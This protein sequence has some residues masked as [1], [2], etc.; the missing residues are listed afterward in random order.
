MPLNSFVITWKRHRM[1][2]VKMSNVP[3]RIYDE[4]E[5][6]YTYILY[7]YKETVKDLHELQD[8][9][10][11]MMRDYADLLVYLQSNAS[12]TYQAWLNERASKDE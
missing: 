6:E 1:R 2:R 12:V 8:K 10:F 3:K 9:N 7:N 11:K 5:G 4:L